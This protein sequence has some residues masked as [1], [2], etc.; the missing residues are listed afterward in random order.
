[1]HKDTIK[2]I[3]KALVNH[4]NSNCEFSGSGKYLP[5]MDRLAI[6]FSGTKSEKYQNYWIFTLKNRC[7]KPTRCY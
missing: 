6:G 1:M 5:I 7:R 2:E 4:M 3:E